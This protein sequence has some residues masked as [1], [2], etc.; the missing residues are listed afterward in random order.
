MGSLLEL[1]ERIN[2]GELIEPQQ[3][4]V[5]QESANAAE[6]FL[7][8]HARAMLELRRSQSFLHDALEAIDFGDHKVLQQYL[9]ILGFLGQNEQRTESVVRFAA[10]AAGR[11]EAAVAMEALQ[12]VVTLDVPGEHAYTRDHQNALF[13]AEK[14][15]RCAAALGWTPV[16]PSDWKNPHLKIGYLTTS[17][18]DDEPSA[19]LIAALGRHSE[20]AKVHVYTTE[21]ACRREKLIFTAGPFLSA[22]TK[23]GKETIDLL[24]KKKIGVT[25]APLDQDLAAATRDLANQIHRDQIDV[26]IIDAG[27]G[28]AIASVLAHLPVSRE[29]LHMVRR[30]PMFS[31]KIDGVAYVDF[32]RLKADEP[33]WRSTEMPTVLLQEGVEP[34]PENAAGPQRSG[35][36]IPESAT[37]LATVLSE[38]DGPATTEFMEAIVHLLRQNPGTVLLVAGD[39]DP[40]PIKRRLEAAGLSKRAG[41]TG[42]RKDMADFLR[43]ADVFLA[44]VPRASSSGM[45]AAMNAARPIVAL[46]GDPADPQNAAAMLGDAHVAEDITAY[47]AKAATFIKDAGLRTKVGAELKARVSEG[48]LMK[49]TVEALIDLC[50]QMHGEPEQPAAKA[51]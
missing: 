12:S 48:F 34:L 4:D 28:D 51:A 49:Q 2:K 50:R 44:S 16:T 29:K 25:F 3:L 9:A 24:G 8:S 43:V 40:T 18:A 35:F 13:I 7:A 15:E 46:A 31:G 11:R 47:L 33:H 36:G 39:G 23:R 41:Y 21:A 37:V 22:S 5:Y 1:V 38:I 30:Q 32:P 19:K 42:K 26:L 6:K 20:G 27:P 17:I 45:L 10:A 14:Y